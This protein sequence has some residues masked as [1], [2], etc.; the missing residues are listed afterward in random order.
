MQIMSRRSIL[1]KGSLCSK[2]VFWTGRLYTKMTKSYKES[3]ITRH[4]ET[5]WRAKKSEKRRHGGKRDVKKSKM[6]INSC[7]WHILNEKI[8]SECCYNKVGVSICLT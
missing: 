4:G 3:N 5:S 8:V 6:L 1:K 7:Q 2:I